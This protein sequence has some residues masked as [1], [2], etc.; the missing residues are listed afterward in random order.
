MFLSLAAAA[1]GWGMARA[2]YMK[3]G[4][5][6]T[7]PIAVEAPPLYRLL[8]NKW[9]VDEGYDYVFTGRRKLGSVRL[10]AM[11]A[12]EAASWFDDFLSRAP[13]RMG[14]GAVVRAGHGRRA[15]RVCVLLRVEMKWSSGF[16]LLAFS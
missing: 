7:E 11:G 4:K 16:W 1:V 9:F 12:G 8:Y 6:Y 13:V 15:R 2:S 14:T 10:G 5:D 3:A